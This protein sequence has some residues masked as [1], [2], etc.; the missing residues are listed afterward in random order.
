MI[1]VKVIC[2][3]V[4]QNVRYLI[5]RS[6]IQRDCGLLQLRPF[7]CM[8]VQAFQISVIDELVVRSVLEL[9]G[10][11]IDAGR[12]RPHQCAERILRIGRIDLEPV[13]VADH[14]FLDPVALRVL[15]LPDHFI[16]RTDGQHVGLLRQHQS[17]VQ[18]DHGRDL[19]PVHVVR[20]HLVA[21][22][23]LCTGRSV[24]VL[25]D[26]QLILGRSAVCI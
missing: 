14:R 26:G 3:A 10:L 19:D 23:E 16:V 12:D 5:R 4:H 24:V 9:R 15:I 22:V 8:G 6:H 7:R 11:C 17:A 13:G 25:V 21:R 18:L 20:D 2:R 1:R